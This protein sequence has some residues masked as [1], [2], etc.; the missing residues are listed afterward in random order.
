[1]TTRLLTAGLCVLTVGAWA[2]AKRDEPPD[3]K[4]V[5]VIAKENPEL[6]TQT[7]SLSSL[8]GSVVSDFDNRVR[9][10]VSLRAEAEKTV[11]K[12]SAEATPQQMNAH[13][14][15]LEAEIARRRPDAAPGAVFIPGMQIYIRAV[16]KR[17]ITGPD[18]AVIKASLM[19]ENP[20]A[21]RVAINERY[22]DTV[23]MSTMP[24]DVLAAL[25]SLPEDLEY[26]FVGNR[27][28]L[29]DIRSQLVVDF[30]ENTFEL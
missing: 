27:L 7:P 2:C 29:L 15:A 6:L 26:R 3:A 28:L 1:M 30:V 12:V 4:D 8:E 21:A 20:M 24:P 23:P 18:G 25:P 17:V 19:D 10:Y 13:Q 11:P 22:P 14:R 5:P 16:V 9:E